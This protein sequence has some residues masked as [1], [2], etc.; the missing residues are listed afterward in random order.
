MTLSQKLTNGAI[1]NASGFII[2]FIIGFFSS[3][4][5]VRLLGQT[6]YG[7]VTFILSCVFFAGIFVNLGF[8]TVM[9]QVIAI[10]RAKNRGTDLKSLLKKITI[11]RLIILVLITILFLQTNLIS[12]FLN[13]PYLSA[14]MIFVPLIIFTSYF[15]GTLSSLL[16]CYYYQKVINITAIIEIMLKLILVITAIQMG[17]GVLGFLMALILSQ[18]LSASTLVYHSKQ[19][20]NRFKDLPQT[21]FMLKKHV[22]LA[23]HSYLVSISVRLL[24]REVDLFLIGVLHHDIREVAIYAVVFGLPKM[25]FDIFH[26]LIGGGLGLSA[27]T[28]YVKTG[29]I[30]ELRHQYQTILHLFSIGVFPAIIGGVII[31]GDITQFVYGDE[32]ANLSIPLA[33]LFF[34]LGV[35]TISTV[36]SDI[37]YALNREK[38]LMQLQ[39]SVGIINVAVNIMVISKYGALGVAITTGVALIIITLFEMVLI[40]KLI[41]PNYPIK[42][43]IIYLLFSSVMGGIITWLP[44]IFYWKVIIGIIIYG[45]LLAVYEYFFNQHKNI[46]MLYNICKV[47]R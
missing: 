38:L 10:N 21:P 12:D 7:I 41:K 16:T 22:K 3:I 1:W 29:Q 43:W 27:F 23:Y 4:L 18:L 26:H 8:G 28:E 30:D 47:S 20:L 11:P 39:T 9:T 32:Y 15:Q 25:V 14:Y 6:Q 5:F 34:S 35:S 42:N 13:K 40:H 24:G 19:L 44:L 45:G 33:I 46:Q 2:K 17:Y 37:L 36:T 31:G